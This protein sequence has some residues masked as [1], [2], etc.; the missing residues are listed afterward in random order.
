MSSAEKI[1][2]PIQYHL[3]NSPIVPAKVNAI[4]EIKCQDLERFK[5][6]FFPS[7]TGIECSFCALSNSSSC[8]E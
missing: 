4:I 5:A 2:N 7:K 8:K 1:A 3:P 6:F